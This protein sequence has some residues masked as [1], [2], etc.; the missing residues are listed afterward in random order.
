MLLL[1]CR[2]CC[3]EMFWLK[4]WLW[5]GVD[6]SEGVDGANNHKWEIQ[7]INRKIMQIIKGKILLGF[8]VNEKVSTKHTTYF[9]FSTDLLLE[10]CGQYGTAV[11]EFVSGD[12]T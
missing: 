1:V 4:G 12:G 7:I 3:W 6:G 8:Q 10:G 5:F 11:D 9:P 2:N